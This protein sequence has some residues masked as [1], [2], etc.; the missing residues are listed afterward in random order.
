MKELCLNPPI[1]AAARKTDHQCLSYIEATSFHCLA[2]LVR[3]AQ[4]MMG[5]ENISTR[6]G[7]FDPSLDRVTPSHRAHS[8]AGKPPLTLQE[9]SQVKERPVLRVPVPLLQRH[10]IEW[11][12]AEGLLLAV[13]HHHFGR[14]SVQAGDILRGG[15]GR[16]MLSE[17]QPASRVAALKQNTVRLQQ[18]SFSR[19]GG[20]W[21]KSC[22]NLARLGR[23]AHAP[24]ERA[25]CGP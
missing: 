22:A 23:A 7:D 19:G 18:P 8:N 10:P 25:R 14:V 21:E 5:L 6:A 17:T 15:G 12:Q 3:Y 1:A 4:A 9:G 24:R 2:P 13:H 16:M 20:G 11:L